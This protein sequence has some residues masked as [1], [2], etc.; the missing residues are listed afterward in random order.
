MNPV[1]TAL[2][3]PK[4]EARKLA[5]MNQLLSEWSGA[6]SESD[7]AP[8]AAKAAEMV[9]DGFYPF[10]FSQPVRVLFIGRESVDIAGCNYLEI[11]CGSYRST[12]HVGGV[13]LNRHHFHRRM[14]KTAHGLLTGRPH[15]QEIPDAREIG[16]N[17]ATASGISFAFINLCKISNE[18]GSW[19]ADQPTI[20]AFVEA[21]TTGRNFYEEQIALLEPEFVVAM[22]LG[23]NLFKLGRLHQLGANPGV[24]LFQLTSKSHPSLLLHTFHFSAANKTDS[25]FY[26]AICTVLKER[27]L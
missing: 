4:T 6:I 9:T 13:A 23:D 15:W 1:P 27:S 24:D 26:P 2:H 14:L 7:S 16:E 17:F 8:L 21:S 12:K 10:Y 19:Q 3:Y 25:L 5:E 11:L 20:R 22:N 18:S